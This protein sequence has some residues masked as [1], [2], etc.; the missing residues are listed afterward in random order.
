MSINEPSVMKPTPHPQAVAA[1]SWLCG[2]VEVISA[3]AIPPIA[4]G[5]GGSKCWLYAY[6]PAPAAMATMP[7]SWVKLRTSVD[8]WRILPLSRDRPRFASVQILTMCKITLHRGSPQPRRQLPRPARSLLTCFAHAPKPTMWVPPCHTP[9]GD[10]ATRFSRLAG[11]S[12]KCSQRW[13]QS[14][15]RNQGTASRSRFSSRSPVSRSRAIA[16]HLK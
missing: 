2:L 7:A 4:R 13:K 11:R 1:I 6:N 10:Y 16:S 12:S 8:L 15:G 5:S 3:A 14:G 9:L